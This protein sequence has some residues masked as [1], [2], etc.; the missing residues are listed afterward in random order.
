[1]TGVVRTRTR[2]R[3]ADATDASG[4]NRAVVPDADSADI[5]D[6]DL[7]AAVVADAPDDLDTARLRQVLNMLLEGRTQKE[8]AAHFDKNVRTIRRW[9]IEAKRR[10]LALTEGLTPQQALADFLYCCAAQMADLLRMKSAAEAQGDFGVAVRCSR[11]LLRH[12]ATRMAVLERLGL[13]NDL[14]IGQSISDGSRNANVLVEAAENVLTGKFEI[15]G[16]GGED[17]GDQDDDEPIF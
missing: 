13:F 12:E 5:A 6:D 16:C 14:A 4:T 7:D 2:K 11:E 10:K 15:D 8:I 1:M 3:L 9:I 17:Q